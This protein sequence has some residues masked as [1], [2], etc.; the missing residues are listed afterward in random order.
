[1]SKTTIQVD[2]EIK[3]LLGARKRVTDESHNDVLRRELGLEVEDEVADLTSYLEPEETDEVTE[4]IELLHEEFDLEED[5][6]ESNDKGYPALRFQHPESKMPLVEI[7]VSTGSGSYS[8]SIRDH[9]GSMR[10]WIQFGSE[11]DPDSER[12]I[13][14]LRRQVN[15]GLQKFG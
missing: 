8:V 10:S 6:T 11:F 3:E 14:E 5:Y 1:M 15:G 7:Q 9:D 12:E 13:S 2:T 4:I